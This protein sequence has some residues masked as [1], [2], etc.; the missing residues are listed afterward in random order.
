MPDRMIREGFVH[1]PR[2]NTLSDR[3]ECA[4]V[5]LLLKV[6]DFGVYF[7]EPKLVRAA[8]WPMKS[9]RDAEVVRALDEI[10]RAGLLA[11]FTAPDG[12]RYLCLL[13]FRQKLA[14]GYRRRHPAPPFDEDTGEMRLELVGESPPVARLKKNKAGR[15]EEK[16]NEVCVIAPPAP[17]THD[18]VGASLSQEEWLES[19]RVQWVGV[20]LADELAK[21]GTYVRSKRG[22]SA[23]LTRKFFVESWLPGCG[24]E[25]DEV[26]LT[27]TKP[28]LVSAGEP[29]G[30]RE[31]LRGTVL[32]DRVADEALAWKDLNAGQQDYARAQVDELRRASA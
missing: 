7:A 9:V 14:Y 27:R 13:R 30:W 26:V 4:F 11:R 25:R 19:L 24:G 18:T 6:D 1:S 5:R 31:A 23:R 3:A 32:G 22:A 20:D 21:A 17:T 2:V 28:L 16:R 12:L 8:I 15:S 29:D 10:E